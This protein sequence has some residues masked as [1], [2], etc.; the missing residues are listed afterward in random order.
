MS[1]TTKVNGTLV[2]FYIDNV[3]VA[4]STNVSISGE[5]GEI[6]T[7][8]KDSSGN[9]EM[10]PGLRSWSAS[11]DFLASVVPST[12]NLDLIYTAWSA[13]TQI[14][15]DVTTGVTGDIYYEGDCYITGW[16]ADAPTEDKVSGSFSIKGTGALSS[17][18]R[19]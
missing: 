7:T 13:G 16:G 4:W 10:L 8:T 14:H 3:A 6:D 5:T 12:G 18:T 9:F 15:M 17:T 11:C 2:L 19:T 1:T